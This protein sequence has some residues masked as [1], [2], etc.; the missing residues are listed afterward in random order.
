MRAEEGVLL[1]LKRSLNRNFKFNFFFPLSF[2]EGCMVDNIYI[3]AG[4]FT[5]LKFFLM[6]LCLSRNSRMH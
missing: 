3:R 4:S 5:Q 1:L 2:R 6:T